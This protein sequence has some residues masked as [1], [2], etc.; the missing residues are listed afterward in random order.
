MIAEVTAAG[1]K[2]AVDKMSAKATRDGFGPVIANCSSATEALTIVHRTVC[3][4]FYEPIAVKPAP[5]PADTDT[6]TDTDTAAAA[7]AA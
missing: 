6:D 7:A 4:P 2:I 3:D 5:K 1:W